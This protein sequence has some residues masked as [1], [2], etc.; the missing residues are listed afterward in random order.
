MNNETLT[1]EELKQRAAK[2]EVA[3]QEA[4]LPVF[5][6]RAW[7]VAMGRED[8]TEGREEGKLYPFSSA[9][10]FAAQR[11]G[12]HTGSALESIGLIIFMSLLNEDEVES[13]RSHAGEVKYRAAF[14]TWCDA[15]EI[16]FGENPVVAKMKDVSD[17][18]WEMELA[19][20][21]KPKVGAGKSK[22]SEP[23]NE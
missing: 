18:I 14:L 8:I 16:G 9:R 1:P 12:I 4:H 2:L 13:T 23:G 6:P 7:F 19:S 15:L 22:A 21:S 3:K 17:A 10:K 5:A 20:K 11:M